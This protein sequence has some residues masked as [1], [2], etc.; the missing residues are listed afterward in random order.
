MS[1]NATC[2]PGHGLPEFGALGIPANLTTFF[3]PGT[4]ISDASM[5][6][7]CAPNLVHVASG[8]YE[9]CEVPSSRL[10]NSSKQDIEIDM[11]NCLEDNGRDFNQTGGILG[12][13][14][15]NGADARAMT[16]GECWIWLMVV[17]G[18]VGFVF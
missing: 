3:I 1:K 5:T 12:V 11:G 10:H 6:T 16:I 8:C 7:C 17:S 9:W 2:P 14:V 18:V 13:H 4:N 15:A